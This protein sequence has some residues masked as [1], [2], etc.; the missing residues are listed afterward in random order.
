MV[1]TD[2][3]LHSS[4][5]T[6]DIVVYVNGAPWSCVSSSLSGDVISQSLRVVLVVFPSPSKWL[7]LL[8]TIFAYYKKRGG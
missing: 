5:G 8:G 4:G 7:F 2:T 1:H 6:I 3:T